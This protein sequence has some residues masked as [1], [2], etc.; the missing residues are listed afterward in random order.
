MFY[1][2][3]DPEIWER[4]SQ[5]GNV[6]IGPT[7]NIRYGVMS[8]RVDPETGQIGLTGYREEEGL[9]PVLPSMFFPWILKSLW[10]WLSGLLAGLFG[11]RPEDNPLRMDFHLGYAVK[12]DAYSPDHGNGNGVNNSGALGNGY[13]NTRRR[14]N[15][16]YSFD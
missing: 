4:Y 14:I 3:L 7:T 2:R 1:K 13:S 12:K 16:L 8:T 9:F 5:P 11:I 10:N 15:D 6:Y